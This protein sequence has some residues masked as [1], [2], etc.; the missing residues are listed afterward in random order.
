MPEDFDDL[1]KYAKTRS[2]P[3]DISYEVICREVMGARQRAELRKLIGFSFTRHQK[4]NLP[5]E[6]LRSIEKYLERR[7]RDLLKL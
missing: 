5:E 4:Y 1:D 7:V 2:N 6:H 3:Y